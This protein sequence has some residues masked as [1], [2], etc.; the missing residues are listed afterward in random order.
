M[1]EINMSFAFHFSGIFGRAFSNSCA[2]VHQQKLQQACF[3]QVLAL[4][5]ANKEGS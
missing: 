5:R 3:Y 2:S 1:P 4:H